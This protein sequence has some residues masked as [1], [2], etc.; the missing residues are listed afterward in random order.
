MKTKDTDIQV[1]GASLYFLPVE[2]RIPLKFGKETLTSVTCSR[3]KITV[4]DR[5]GRIAEGWGE[6]PL[7][8]QWVWPGALSYQERFSALRD[9]S[10]KLVDAWVGFDVAGHPMEVGHAFQE[11]MLKRMLYDF[12]SKRGK[13]EPMP[14]LAA[15]V[16][17][18]AFD[19]ALHDAYGI[20]LGMP[21]YETYNSKFMNSDLASYLTP[22]EGSNISFEGKYPEDFFVKP[23]IKMP[24]WHLVGGK[25]LIDQN[26]LTGTEPDDGYPVLL[27]DWIRRDG[28]KCLKIKLRGND[29][30]WDYNRLIKVGKIAEE[31][32]V[33]WLTTDFN[34]TVT[35]VFYVDAILDRLMKEYPKI[36]G[37]ILYVEQPFPY[38]L[39]NNQIDVHSVSARKPLFMDESCHDWHLIKLGRKLGWSGVALKTCKTQTGAILSACWAKAHGMTLMVQD[40]TN[41]MLAQIPHCLLAAHVGTIAGVESNAMQFYPEASLPEAE[42]HP[43][44]YKRSNG[45]VDISSLNGPGFGYCINQINRELPE[46][47]CE[48]NK[49]SWY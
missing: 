1:V 2:T 15:L 39:E 25:D 20:A 32:G 35:D 13:S 47:V 7:S 40:L 18:S 6:T 36:Y 23:R 4:V 27:R 12:N 14:W 19:I 49:G 42:V 41:P 43:G 5:K 10:V 30:E 24:V 17:C 21:I 8:V 45:V 33:D 26:E 46:P 11:T 38:D 44:I 48:K 31:E 37:M 28:L 3:V 29:S 34:C 9:F 16:C 22:A